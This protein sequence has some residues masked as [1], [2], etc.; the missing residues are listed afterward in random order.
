MHIHLPQATHTDILQSIFDLCIY[1]SKTDYQNAH[2]K[3]TFLPD[4]VKGQEVN[5]SFLKRTEFL[6]LVN[7]IHNLRAC[8]DSYWFVL[9]GKCGSLKGSYLVWVLG[10]QRSNASSWTIFKSVTAL[11]P[12]C[13]LIA[14][15][16]SSIYA[17][18]F[19]MH[20]MVGRM[21]S[22]PLNF[23]SAKSRAAKNKIR[24]GDFNTRIPLS[25]MKVVH[26]STRFFQ[27]KLKNVL[28]HH[29]SVNMKHYLLCTQTEARGK[30]P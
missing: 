10:L 14:P 3:G 27:P 29:N 17:F 15:F 7:A 26:Y 5:G 19:F 30:G 16:D 28:F 2:V 23:V 8:A 9:I 25:S 13:W 21:K 22:L 11:R 18:F 6:T 20:N 24:Q 1:R 4:L 12:G